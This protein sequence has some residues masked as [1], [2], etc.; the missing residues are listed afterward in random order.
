MV[1]DAKHAVEVRLEEIIVE[2]DPSMFWPN[3]NRL[4]FDLCDC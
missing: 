4:F 1:I 3:H 2:D